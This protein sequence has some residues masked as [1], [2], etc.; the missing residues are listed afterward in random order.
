M[1]ERGGVNRRAL[2]GGAWRDAIAAAPKLATGGP[3]AIVQQMTDRAS[4]EPGAELP[5]PPPPAR[6][7]VAAARV[8]GSVSLDAL[9]ARARHVGLGARADAIR[10]LVRQSVRLTLA[11]SDDSGAAGSRIGGEP[12]ATADFS[13]PTTPDGSALDFLAQINLADLVR[14]DV[15]S[16]LP[17]AGLLL[18]FADAGR[19]TGRVVFAPG[20]IDDVTTTHHR[21]RAKP[22]VPARELDCCVELRLPRPWSAPVEALGLNEDERDAWEEIRTWLADRQGV[23]LHDQAPEF[24]ALH[25]MFGYP[26][27]TRGDMRLICELLSAGAVFERRCPRDHPLASELEPAARRWRLLLQLSLDDR[28]GWNWGEGV[29]RL[30]FWIDSADAES[31]EFSRARVIAQ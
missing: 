10:S 14:I 20:T 8:S 30:Y 5:P 19:E 18:F 24:L 1:D 9:V 27:E 15:K 17:T 25:R 13:W 11:E 23:E 2:F 3:L 7:T 26:D 29:D 22:L 21:P 16:G 28:I 4:A 6:R 31:A 12:G